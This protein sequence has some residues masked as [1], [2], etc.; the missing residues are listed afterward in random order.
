MADRPMRVCAPD[1]DGKVRIT[2]PECEARK[3][4]P[5][6]RLARISGPVS[7][8]CQC[9]AVFSCGLGLAKNA[10]AS[11]PV[12]SNRTDPAAQHPEPA[13]QR[14]IQATQDR[15]FEFVTDPDG[16]IR[17]AC[18]ACGATKTVRSEKVAHLKQPT[19]LKCK[20]GN[21]FLCRFNLSPSTNTLPARTAQSAPAQISTFYPDD[22][23]RVHVACPRCQTTRSVPYERV[24]QHTR[25][26]RTKC[27][28]CGLS[29]PVRFLPKEQNPTRRK[30]YPEQTFYAD[31][32]GRVTIICPACDKGRT[33]RSSELANVKQPTPIR[34][35]CGAIFPSRFV[36]E[37]PKPE[38][39]QQHRLPAA[40]RK[41]ADETR[42][43]KTM[44]ADE[45][46]RYFR[47]L[48]SE[49]EHD[50]PVFPNVARYEDTVVLA[51]DETPPA[52]D[53]VFNDEDIPE[54]DTVEL[55]AEPVADEEEAQQA[56]EPKPVRKPYTALD[57]FEDD[58]PLLNVN[59]EMK[60]PAPCLHCKRVN[61]L[62]LA[63]ESDMITAARVNCECGA[64]YPVRLEYRKTYRKRVSL[65]GFY[66]D[67][68]GSKRE[69][70]VRDISLGGVGFHT[71]EPHKL[72][73]RRIVDVLFH[74][75]DAKGTRI[76]RKVMVRNVR[77]RFVGVQFLEQRERDKELGFYLMA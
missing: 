72:M 19:K 32:G 55:V 11:S 17:I 29:F 60:V 20:C 76:F 28:S 24:R 14:P 64:Q 1:A 5:A 2:C 34:C 47:E 45:L 42:H 48:E 54:V 9:G 69:M 25:P 38:D 52:N 75:D 21:E 67:E 4:L 41:S 58:W 74:L 37:Q 49:P 30:R 57:E 43:A 61:I 71:R 44:H 59:V 23:D 53:D 63:G 10:P 70:V 77:G 6:E 12:S 73:Q 51:R 33:L 31:I 22:A 16:M 7:L 8:R 35:S 62:D 68:N 15:V 46:G 40:E 3:V 27:P 18:P 56:V 26:V 36:L 39:Q 13:S 66:F 65:D 50:M